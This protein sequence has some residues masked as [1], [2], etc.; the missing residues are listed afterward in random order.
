MKHSLF[1]DQ[2]HSSSYVLRAIAS[3]EG[4][5]GEPYDQ[6]VEAAGELDQLRQ[7]LYDISHG[8]VPA[9]EMPSLDQ[10]PSEFR[11]QMWAW[12]QKHAREALGE[13]E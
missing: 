8:M 5:D 11:S 2:D 3:Q 13:G 10:E 4:C 9:G 7:A 6:M 12:S 1:G